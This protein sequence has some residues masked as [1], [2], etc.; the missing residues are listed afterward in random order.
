LPLLL[1][2]S[3]TILNNAYERSLIAAQ[4]SA[5]RSQ[6]YLL[7][8]A[9]EPAE[10]G[11]FL[12]TNLPEPR[13]STVSSGLVG[14]IE[15]SDHKVEWRSRSGELL[16]LNLVPRPNSEF[17]PGSERFFD[18]R[19]AD[20]NYFAISYDT[21]WDVHDR[22]L[23]FRFIVMQDQE[24]MNTE[25]RVYQKRLWQWL[26]GM[27]LLLI[28]VQTLIARWGLS[29]LRRL[30]TD[31]ESIE[32]GQQQ[33]LQGIYPA[34]IQPVTNNLN[35]VLSSEQQQRDRYRNTLADLAHSLKTP[36]AVIRGHLQSESPGTKEQLKTIIDEQISRMSSIVDH[37]LRR[38]TAQVVQSNRHEV[39]VAAVA[40]RLTKALERVYQDRAL[41]ITLAIDAQLK[42]IGDE[43]DLMELLGNVI[44]N[45]CKY[46]RHSVAV[47]AQE[48]NSELHIKV[49]D[50][51]NGVA[52]NM[53]QTVLNR[54]AR[55]DTANPGQGIGLAVAVD[56]LSSYGG[57][58][59]IFKSSLGGACFLLRIPQ[60]T[61]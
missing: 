41:E 33:N 60:C 51:G 11:I 42:F 29:P 38:A 45:A 8:D 16:D 50:D 13:Y 30:A 27:A 34:E 18:Y 39:F 24:P 19:I 44:D 7:L 2:L 1:G 4:K 20:K 25:L 54:G 23:G 22:D 14:W 3:A 35:R 40:E 12:A 57:A 53:K 59:E 58:I 10:N 36:L 61:H 46:G 43:G 52:E 31:L 15:T 55:A 21:I 48:V 6:I 49:E 32:S 17:N 5:L 47:S 28:L 37:Q 9:A 26:G 56:I